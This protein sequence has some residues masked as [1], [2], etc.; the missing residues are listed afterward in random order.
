[1]VKSQSKF[2]TMPLRPPARAPFDEEGTHNLTTADKSE[3]GCSVPR[4]FTGLEWI[5]KMI[6]CRA[7]P[8]K[9]GTNNL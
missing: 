3:V 5:A 1:M 6:L 4:G 2:E 9:T 7:A 8:P